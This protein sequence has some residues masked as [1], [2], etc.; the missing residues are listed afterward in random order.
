MVNVRYMLTQRLLLALVLIFSP[1]VLAEESGQPV[2]VLWEEGDPA[3]PWEPFN[4]K[5][6]AFNE[7]AD[8]Y[9]LRP[10]AKGY[11]YITPDP[12]ENGVS[13]F[14]SN[15]YEFNTIVNSILQGRVDNTIHSF[16]R[17]I[18]N[19]TIGLLG[20]I[21][22]A[23]KMGVDHRP[24]D[25]GQTLYVWGFDSGPF[26]MVPIAGPRT[27]RSGTGLLVDSYMTIPSQQNENLYNWTFLA[28]EAIDIRAQLLKAD[29]LI[30]GDRYIFLREAYLSQREFFLSGGEIED[31]FS[32]FGEGE[33]YEE[34]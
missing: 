30:S 32:D 27:V 10:V 21:D 7:A 25:F 23:T 4:R 15:I 24:A 8:K 14:I 26:L 9:V 16:G 1:G 34:F 29:Q 28:V 31:D 19:S 33:D 17:F 6:F 13:N 18:I 20:F 5:M 12:V 22:V 3:D 2:G 11:R